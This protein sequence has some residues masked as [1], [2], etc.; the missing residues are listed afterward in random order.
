MNATLPKDD[1]AEISARRAISIIESMPSFAWSADPEGRYTYVSP[2]A[3]A[4]LGAPQ[5]DLDPLPGEDEFGWRRVVHPDDY[6]R[7]AARWRH[8]L[9]TGEHYDTEHRLRRTDGVYRWF[10]NSGRA[11]RDSEGR[12]TQWHGTTFD[13]DDQKQ[14]EAALRERENELSRLVDLVPSHVWRLGADGE[15]TF[16][17]KRMLDFLGWSGGQANAASMM[18]LDAIIDAVHPDDAPEFRKRLM[19]SLSTGAQFT[20]RYRLRRADGA[21]RWMSSR[22]EALRD[23]EGRII[24]WYGLCHDIDDQMQAEQALRRNERQ[25]QQIIDA[26]PALIWCT[27]PDGTPSYVNQRLSETVG[28]SLEDLLDPDAPRSLAD[29][30]PEDRPAVD[31][32]LLHSFET[33]EPFA[34]KYRQRRSDGAYRWTEGRAEP[35]RDESGAIVQWYGV[36]VDID[37]L[38]HL[39]SDLAERESRIRRLVDSDIIGIVIWDLDGTLVDANDAFLRMVQYDREDLE[40]GLQWFD[41]TPPEW[42]EVHAAEEAEELAGTGKMLPREKEYFRKDGS[43]VSVLIGAACFEGQ[44]SRGVAY[45]LD[46]TEQKRAEAAVRER[47][48]ELSQLVDMVPS[49]LWRITPDGVPVFFNRRLV[50]FLGLDVEGVDGPEGTRLRA[51][52][53]TI[54][55]PDDAAGVADAFAH[56]L[57]SGEPLSMKWRMRRSDGVYRWMS[58][59]AEAMRD[60]DGRIVQWYGL[61]HDTHD[62]ALAEEALRNSKRQLQQMIDALPINILSFDPQQ[63]LTYASRRYADTVGMPESSVQ[64]FEMLARDVVHP[65]EFPAMFARASHGFA[66]GQSFVNRFRRRCSDG[67]YRWIE[68]RT[69]ALRD[70][71]GEIIQWYIVSIDIEEEMQ[72]QE[73]LRERERFLWQLVETLPAMIDCAAPNGDPVYRSQQLRQYLGYELEEL[74]AKGKLRLDATLDAGVHPDDLP[75]VREVYAHSLSTGQPYARRHRLRRHDGVY[76]WVETRAAPMRNADGEIVQWNVICLDIDPEVQA[77]DELRLA[78]EK[79]ARAS[80]AASLAELSASIAHEV[81]QPLAAVVANSYACQRW[82]NSE[83]PNLDRAQ[84]TVDRIIRDANAAGEVVSRIRALFKSSSNTRIPG[85]LSA[86]VSEAVGL[87]SEEALRRGIR[88]DVDLATTLPMVPLDRIQVQQVL[89]NLIRNGMEAMEGCS[90]PRK[91]VVR[92][93]RTDDAIL[94]EVSD[95]G[96]GIDAPERIFEPFYTTKEDGMGMGLA[97]CRSIIESHGGKLWAEKNH[98][99]GATFAFTLPAEMKAAQ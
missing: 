48:R 29:I 17:N 97:I 25:L 13:I 87:M 69:Q 5:T 74:D 51:I 90:G 34:M 1:D 61:C 30:H 47:E 54:I 53:E 96:A 38:T 32:A 44:S 26:V 77:Q 15:P 81:N 85:S 71:D 58:S 99:C 35:F 10:R 6:D 41:M 45:I 59:S 7:V 43:R 62:Q 39:Y 40:E 18:R 46:L 37:E 91:L 95:F 67:V 68:A 80:Q 66:T 72:A 23:N 19:S 12:I 14:V 11:L 64:N 86:I 73:A 21:Y 49:F 82:L 98:P 55:H 57:A 28:V 31:E 9:R 33:G 8:C 79:M 24:Q 94:T 36:C 78:Q 70:A 4:Y 88:L 16:F 42:Q 22:A 2:N 20:S 89:V 84:R 27:T 93:A 75:G 52:I 83:P 56:S 3:L 60:H 65:D 63:N 50:D 76:R 92:V